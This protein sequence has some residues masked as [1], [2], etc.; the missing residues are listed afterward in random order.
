LFCIPQSRFRRRWIV[1]VDQHSDAGRPR[2]QLTQ[3]R[4]LLGH[5]LGVENID[6]CHVTIWSGEAG[7]EA[8][9]NRVFGEDSNNRYRRRCCLCGK[10]HWKPATRDD[11]SDLAPNEIGRQLWHEIQVILGPAVDDCNV[12]AF[13]IA[14]V[15]KALAKNP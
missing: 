7:D 1:R 14:V 10:H 15:L 9:P 4:E 13:Q 6:S 8:E 12:I 2:Y 11:Y 3:E 5:Q